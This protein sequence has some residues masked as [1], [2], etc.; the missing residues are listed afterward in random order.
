[1]REEFKMFRQCFYQG[2]AFALSLAAF[3]WLFDLKINIT[4]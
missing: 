2:M 3:V 1:M 4:F